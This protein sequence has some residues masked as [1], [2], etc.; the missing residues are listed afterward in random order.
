MSHAELLKSEVFAEC[1]RQKQT[2][3]IKF[4]TEDFQS[5]NL[6]SHETECSIFE[7]FLKIKVCLDEV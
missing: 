7:I 6:M 1:R 5:L 4:Y 2:F 3:N